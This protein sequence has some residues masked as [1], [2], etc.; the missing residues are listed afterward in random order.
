[1]ANAG[2]DPAGKGAG[3]CG[4]RG[5]MRRA[6]VRR[7]PE[8]P[9]V[10]LGRKVREASVGEITE[11]DLPLFVKP[12]NEKELSGVVANDM[13]DLVEHAS[14]GDDYRAYCSDPVDFAS[15]CRLFIRRGSLV[16]ARHYRGDP[17]VWPD[18]DV[19]NNIIKNL[20]CRPRCACRLFDRP[21]RYA[22]W[23]DVSRRGERRLLA[24]LLRLGFPRCTPSFLQQG[25][26][27]SSAW[28]TP[29]RI[30]TA[31]VFLGKANPWRPD[32]RLYELLCEMPGATEGFAAYAFQ[33]AEW[34]GAEYGMLAAVAWTDHARAW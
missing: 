12:L 15:E 7:L 31:R 23:E 28:K 11:R 2:V 3:G 20:R 6:A 17:H 18:V 29:S 25:G 16:G 4:L 22:W 13:A 5:A 24:G 34:M 32:A 30:L 26:R 27:S 10:F 14:R 1:M 21:R 8:A 9:R 19:V 33:S